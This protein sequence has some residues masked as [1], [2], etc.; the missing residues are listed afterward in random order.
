MEKR[1]RHS[2]QPRPKPARGPIA[3][4]FQSSCYNVGRVPS[5]LFAGPPRPL[6][7]I[8]AASFES[9]MGLAQVKTERAGIVNI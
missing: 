3:P 6:I 5:A 7:A 2:K 9:D 8:L 4:E 1:G